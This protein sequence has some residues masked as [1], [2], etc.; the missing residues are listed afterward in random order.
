[1]PK[2]VVQDVFFGGTAKEL[3]VYRDDTVIW[4]HKMKKPFMIGL[5]KDSDNN[6]K[7]DEEDSSFDWTEQNSSFKFDVIGTVRN[8]AVG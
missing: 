1:L 4:K 8:E 7:V 3:H 5:E 6:G 2:D